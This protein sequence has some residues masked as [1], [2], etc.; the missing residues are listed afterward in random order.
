MG[1][2][3]GRGQE[4]TIGALEEE[5]GVLRRA[6]RAEMDVE[7]DDALREDVGESAGERGERPDGCFLTCLE[8]TVWPQCK[9]VGATRMEEGGHAGH[10]RRGL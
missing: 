3:V 9:V 2:Q 7:E 6:R 8:Q 5:S 4:G 10:W 1:W